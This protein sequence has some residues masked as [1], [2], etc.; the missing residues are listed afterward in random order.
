MP[1][2]Q[3]NEYLLRGSDVEVNYLT[4]GFQGQPY[5]TYNDGHHIRTFKGPE[6][7]ALDTEIGRLVSVTIREAVDTGSTSY[8]VLIPVVNLA[9]RST[10]E[11]FHTI[12]VRTVHKTGLV[13]PSTG[14]RETY[15][16]DFL[17][18]TARAVLV[19]LGATAGA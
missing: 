14:P 10:P 7:R 15:H 2:I 8:S 16:V 5:F 18:G 6:V 17:E 9:D 13:L 4:S 12:G 1:N 3:P 11:K 19:P